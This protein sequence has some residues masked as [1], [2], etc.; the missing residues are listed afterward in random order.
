MMQDKK[1]IK[2]KGPAKVLKICV[3]HLESHLNKEFSNDVDDIKHLSGTFVIT[4][5]PMINKLYA[6][7]IKILKIT[8]LYPLSRAKFSYGPY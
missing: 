2:H 8:M 4:V 6:I 5:E 7:F 3:D 1:G